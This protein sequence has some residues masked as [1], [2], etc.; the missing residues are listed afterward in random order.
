[1]VS[2]PD[3]WLRSAANESI[4]LGR[5]GRKPSDEIYGAEGPDIFKRRS[6]FGGDFAH[7]LI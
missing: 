5:L 7:N 6:G 4:D 1:M 2:G 3:Y